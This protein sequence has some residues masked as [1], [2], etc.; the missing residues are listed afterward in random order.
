ML[1]KC[2]I[3]LVG[4]TAILLSGCGDDF[5]DK[6]P[7]GILTD[8][9]FYKT[10]KDAWN[11]L[12]ACY[13]QFAGE[14]DNMEILAYEL[15]DMPSDDAWKGGL[16]DND[17]PFTSHLQWYVP[18]PENQVC[19]DWYSANYRAIERT[20]TLLVKLPDIPFNDNSLKACYGAEA[21]VLR[22]FYYLN[23]V[24][25]YGGIPLVEKPVMP[26]DQIQR[27]SRE[28]INQFIRREL[29]EA[30]NDLP[31]RNAMNMTNDWGRI[32]KEAAW[33]L[34]ART[35]LFFGNFAEGRDAAKK[36]IDS[37]AF[38]L[39]PQ[40]GDLFFKNDLISK[41]S[42]LERLHKN[43]SG[44]GDEIILPTY[45]RS[46]NTGGWGFLCPTQDLVN[47]FEVGDPRILYTI[48]EEGDIFPHRTF[49]SGQEVQNHQG[50]TTGDGY[51]SRKQF[52]PEPRRS[53]RTTMDKND[54]V[55]RYADVLL[56]YAEG[57]AETSGSLDEAC[58]YINMI[59]A[60]ARNAY[61]YDPEAYGTTPE[62]KK[63]SRVTKIA[64]VDIPDVSASSIEQFRTAL[65][66]ER[67]VELA[68]ESHRVWD[69]RR[70][71]WEYMKPRIEKSRQ[72]VR[73]GWTVPEP[74]NLKLMTYPIP[75]Q[76]ID[77]TEGDVV[78]NPGW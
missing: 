31:S 7:Y 43:T 63:D 51:H 73:P 13:S 24:R 3:F 67:R 33:A 40:F 15:G 21:R 49:A 52:F 69:L 28:E 47:E 71:G 26:G 78:Q 72:T 34:L 50:Y 58:S 5:L 42:I 44:Q 46:R 11:A 18:L 12:V 45:Y 64:D 25:A 23:L 75:Q 77:R 55:I 53:T 48:V 10:E 36:V 29:N 57:L 19:I 4:F 16:N 32:C 20:N 59:R 14:S 54:K 35:E 70:W 8:A 39:E 61:K 2:S 6:P 30:A 41:E 68:T 37:Q 9:S 38:A 60:R 56:M 62:E 22:A 74:A 76:E 27:A 17:R 66:H 1:K 65:R